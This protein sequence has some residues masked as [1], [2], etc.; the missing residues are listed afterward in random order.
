MRLICALAFL[1]MTLPASAQQSRSPAPTSEGRVEAAEP[2][3]PL[4]SSYITSDDYPE[5]AIAKE[6]RGTVN[7]LLTIGTDGAPTDCVV[8][9]S[10]GSSSLDSATC[11]IMMERARFRPAK[12]AA[13]KPTVGAYE[14]KITW[15]LENAG[16]GEGLAASPAV[17]TA[18]NLW[19]SCNSGEAAKLVTS[20]LSAA[21]IATRAFKACAAL[22]ERIAVEIRKAKLKDV[23]PAKMIP[24]LKKGLA[25]RLSD[26]IGSARAALKGEVRK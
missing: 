16:P 11:R 2:A 13:G 21:D 14:G 12:N 10:S 8:T 3:A 20:D 24:T 23:D 15:R 5:E 22:E 18:T 26:M 6:E 17:E 9:N 4:Q 19:I 7:Y 25:E 1:S